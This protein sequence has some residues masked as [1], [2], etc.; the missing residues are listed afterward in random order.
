[1]EKEEGKIIVEGNPYL[2]DQQKISISN[3]HKQHEGSYYIKKCEH[4]ITSQ[5]FKTTLDCLKI[6]PEATIDT[7]GTITQQKYENGELTEDQLQYYHR[8]QTVFGNDV[9]V[10]GRGAGK[11]RINESG[12]FVPIVGTSGTY[13]TSDLQKIRFS[14]LYNPDLNYTK[15]TWAYDMV[16]IY[17]S[18]D[19]KVKNIALDPEGK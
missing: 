5:G 15:D 2:M 11:Q 10:T 3:V 19:G 14:D 13:Q 7:I 4:N 17:N 18:S 12:T 6:S 8:E 16:K 9:L 1:M